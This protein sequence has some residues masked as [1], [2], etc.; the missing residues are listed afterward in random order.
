PRP[1]PRFGQVGLEALDQSGGDL[2][3]FR[4][5]LEE[6]GG[7]DRFPVDVLGFEECQDLGGQGLDLREA[8]FLPIEQDRV[9]ARQRVVEGERLVDETLPYLDELRQRFPAATQPGGA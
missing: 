7:R 9:E 4:G 6:E 3:L 2:L 1:A 5:F 8:A